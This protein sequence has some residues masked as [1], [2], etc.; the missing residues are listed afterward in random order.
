MNWTQ[1]ELIIEL[2]WI[3]RSKAGRNDALQDGTIAERK[4]RK[5]PSAASSSRTG[6]AEDWI[7]VAE[8]R[9]VEQY[10]SSSCTKIYA[11]Q[12]HVESGCRSGA[13]I[14]PSAHQERGHPQSQEPAESEQGAV[15]VVVSRWPAGRTRVRLKV[16]LIRPAGRTRKNRSSKISLF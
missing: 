3:E 16:A 5:R 8:S 6:A 11:I 14:A 12:V 13:G 7:P 9:S 4:R 1:S 10:F 15:V 2:I